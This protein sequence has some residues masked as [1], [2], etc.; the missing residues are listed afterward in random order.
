MRARL[1]FIRARTKNLKFREWSVTETLFNTRRGL[2][3]AFRLAC[4]DLPAEP[5]VRN[6]KPHLLALDTEFTC[7]LPGFPKERTAFREGRC[8]P[9]SIAWVLFDENGKV[10]PG[11][12][13]HKL[14]SPKREC[15]V[16]DDATAVHGIDT[17]LLVEEG[18]DIKVIVEELARD[19]VIMSENQGFAIGHSFAGDLALVLNEVED[20]KASATEDF[21]DE[22][23]RLG[24]LR[25]M[26]KCED[27]LT[28]SSLDTLKA[29]GEW[30]SIL[31]GGRSGKWM[32]LHDLY[33]TLL[34]SELG[35]KAMFAYDFPSL[36][37]SAHN[38]AADATM[39]GFAYF[40]LRAF[41][42]KPSPTR[43]VEGIPIVYDENNT[44]PS[45]CEGESSTKGKS[46]ALKEIKISYRNLPTEEFDQDLVKRL[47]QHGVMITRES[48]KN[49][50]VSTFMALL[51]QERADGEY[52][53]NG[54]P[55]D[56]SIKNVFLNDNRAT[57]E[58]ERVMGIRTGWYSVGSQRFINV[59]FDKFRKDWVIMFGNQELVRDLPD[60][61]FPTR[62]RIFVQ[63]SYDSD[64]I[65]RLKQMGGMWDPHAKLW[66]VSG[67]HDNS[68]TFDLENFV[69]AS[70]MRLDQLVRILQD[71]PKVTDI[72]TSGIEDLAKPRDEVLNSVPIEGDIQC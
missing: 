30:N 25:L 62:V 20:L 38:S 36:I 71:E 14:V 4:D 57:L 44:I 31:T 10:V 37:D 19:C 3:Y 53:I 59:V 27:F 40:G 69:S 70:G 18:K 5:A 54:K 42:I 22:E 65:A 24:F 34:G 28:N 63:S 1:Q 48:D 29:S 16:S 72:F 8:R 21:K 49:K 13:V 66:F 39:T 12:P 23:E 61:Y 45:K 60:E 7:L 2:A 17:E 68:P 15:E 47:Q 56:D 32:R 26:G 58:I 46:H 52:C 43:P 35:G 9:A 11:Y 33:G 50:K 41:N 55:V 67:I 51:Y 64:L 6:A